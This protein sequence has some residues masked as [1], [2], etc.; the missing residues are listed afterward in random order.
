MN[1]DMNNCDHEPDIF[2]EP[3]DPYCVVFAP[4]LKIIKVQSLMSIV[5]GNIFSL[6]P[7]EP[8]EHA[9]RFLPI[10]F[11]ETREGAEKLLWDFCS[12]LVKEYGNLIYE[13]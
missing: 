6:K 5:C 2:Y 4:E 10:G 1:N 8:K 13:E 11:S 3:F 9:G 12:T 7:H